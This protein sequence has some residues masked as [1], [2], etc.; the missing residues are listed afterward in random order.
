M[1]ASETRDQLL[2]QINS[3]I[4]AN[5]QNLI[6]GPVLNNILDSMVLSSIFNAGTWSQYVTYAVLD[7]VQYGGSSYIATL[8]STNQIPPN[9]TYWQVLASIGPTGATG[10]A[11]PSGGALVTVGTTA[12]N[13]GTTG[14]LLYNNAGTLGNLAASSLTVGAATNVANGAANQVPYQ[15]GSGATSFISAPSVAS[16]YLQWTGSA[17]AWASPPGVTTFSGGTTGLLPST[18]T[19]GAV[20][21]SGT[22]AVANGGTGVTSSTGSGSVVLSSFPTLVSPALG[23]PVSGVMSNVTG[24][25]VSTG[26][27]GTGT[28]VTTA[29]GN[30]VNATGGFVTYSGSLGTPTQGVLTNATGLPLTTGVTGNLPVTNLNSGTGASSTTYWRGDGT[31]GSI[32]LTATAIVVGSTS[33]NSGTSG[34]VLYNNAGVL[35][36]LTNTGTGNNVLATSPTLVTPILGTPTS[37]TLTNATGLPISTGVSGLGTGVATA[38]GVNVGSGGAFVVNGGALGTPS[39]GTL[40]NVNGLPLST[41]V[42]GT[43]PTANGGTGLTGFTAANNAIYSTSSSVLA[44]GTLPVLAGGT[45]VTTS[46][47]SGANVLST[48]PTLVTPILGTPTSVT[49]TN[50]T[51]LPLTT[52][53]TGNLPVTNLNSGTSASSTTFWRGDGTWATPAGGGSGTVNSGTAGQMT[54]YA[55]TGTAV[56]GNP[57]AT[58]SAGALTLGVA[59]TA[60]GS[61]LLSGSTSGAVTVK[62]AAAAGTWTLTLPTTAGTNGYVLSTDGSGGTSWIATS[63]GSGTV[64]SVGLTFSAGAGNILSNSGTASPITGSGTYTL[65][66]TGTSG[67]I[68]YF[69]SASAWSSSAAL[70]QYGVVYGGGAGAAPVATAAGTNGQVLLATTGAAPSWGQVSLTTAVTGTLP[71]T[72]GGTGQTTASAAFNALSPITTIGDLIIGNGTNSAT[73][74]AIGANGYVLTSNG[75]TATW[76]ASTG[77]VTSFQTS[78]SGLTPGITT[79]GAI[80]LAGTLGATSGGTGQSAYATGDILYASATNTLSKLTAGTDGYVLTLASGVPTWAASTGGGVSSFS[81]GTTGFT[82][83]TATTGAVTLAGTLAVTNGGTGQTTASAAFNA[84][85]PITTVGDLIIGNGT[86]SATRLGIGTNGYVLTSNGTTATWAASTGGVTSFSAGTTGLTPNSTTTGSIT[87]AGTLAV[88]NGGTG[89]TVSSGASSVVLRDSNSSVTANSFFEGFTSVAAAGT[90]TTLTAAST[91][92]YV[93]TG[94]G[95]QTYKLPDATTLP[96]GAVFSFNNNQTS[97]TVVVQN[98]TGTTLATL[99]SGSFVDFTLLVNSPAAGSWDNHP[100]PPSNVSWSTNTLDWTGSITS[101]TWNGVAVAANRGGTGQSTYATG[102]ILYASATNTLSKLTAGTNGYVLTLAAGVPTWAAGGSGTVN[103]GTIGQL[104]YYA[105][106]GTAVSGLTTGTGVTTALGVNTGSSGAFVVNGGA[107]GTP[108][109]GTLTNATGLPLTTGVTGNLPVTNLNSGTSAS[110]TTFWCGD[111]TWA[112]P[113]SGGGGLTWQ[114]VQTA[115]F[116]ATAGNAYP[117][118]TTSGAVTVTLPASP[119]A[120]QAIQITDYSGSFAN[121]VCTIARNGS[122]INGSSANALLNLS[123]ESVAFVYIDS[124]QGWITYST[125]VTNISTPYTASYLI[126]AGGGGGGT[127]ALYYEAAGGGAGGLLSG[128]TSLTPGVAYSFTVGAGGAT[129]NNGSNSTAFSLSSIGGGKGGNGTNPNTGGSGGSGGGASNLTGTPGSGTS[130]QGYAGGS[131]TASTSGGGGGAGAVGGAGGAGAAGG[132]GVASTI[133]GSSV[134]YAGGGGGTGGAGGNGG[135]GT[136]S[137]GTPG[138]AGTVNTG[139]GGGGAGG[140]PSA[141]GGAGGSGVVI[142]SVPTA[143]YTGTTTGSPTVTTSG[144]NTIMKFTA[145]GSY[146]A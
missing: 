7:V 30:S 57:N 73:R 125:S 91:P 16:T 59:G 70:T 56:S 23:T 54:Y 47:G 127:A 95:G 106:T 107:L 50:A 45:G 136:G 116:T 134:Y 133:T 135:G 121:N 90:T 25:P 32:S 129:A 79:T 43:L 18:A 88:A 82:P 119:T 37:A 40:T 105:A 22:L 36:N 38:L 11:G 12:V 31:W 19:S 137:S 144:S 138:G 58:I 112:T 28:G 46:T 114:S 17:F 98:S 49:L 131:A 93:V 128:S 64:T 62:S 53:V 123:R 65:A 101:A 120:G 118:N 35:G 13:S 63:G 1:S 115:N 92:I 66:V 89:V 26:L 108:S 55:S 69:S 42:T 84:L 67:G 83:S 29:L 27:A 132:V 51:G 44:A 61:L 117:V 48:S 102:D 5:G 94:S 110:S 72:N 2:A 126:V 3:Q 81:A 145:S 39:S 9:A 74:L 78:L 76:A 142:I 4:I 141:A 77:G 15:T 97:G 68:P 100:Q 124:T 109:S 130:G 14:Y 85:S 146:T 33:V 75:S 41:G 80:T 21:L 24:L 60:A 86:N 99:Q 143:N 8:P 20:T 71:I 10:P 104:T 122:N 34:Y 139:G 111:G 52:G 87:L 140:A 113:A 103:S 96:A 6:T